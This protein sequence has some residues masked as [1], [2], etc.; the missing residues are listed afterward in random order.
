M[1]TKWKI[2]L[3]FYTK[4]F[5]IKFNYFGKKAI[6][7]CTNEA[8]KKDCQEITSLKKLFRG[9]VAQNATITCMLTK[10]K[11]WLLINSTL[12]VHF[13]YNMLYQITIPI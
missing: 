10:F 7:C 13:K 3:N 4:L 2:N 9:C 5:I 12:I 6:A 8:L 11:P 1:K